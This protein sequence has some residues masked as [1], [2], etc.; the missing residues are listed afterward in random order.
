MFKTPFIQRFTQFLPPEVCER[1]ARSTGWLQRRGKIHP[2]EF[3]AGPT[4]AQAS[5]VHPSLSAQG[6]SYQQPVTPQAVDQRYNPQA[7]KFFAAAFEHTLHT[8]LEAQAGLPDRDLLQA[9]F[10][11]VRLF[12]STHFAVSES[13]AA[14]FPACGGG[15][16][17]AGIK[18]LLQHEY[19]R[20]QFQPL[21]LLPGKS[22]DQGL[23]SLAGA[24][25]GPGELGLFDKGF[26]HGAVL[27]EIHERGGYFLIPWPRSVTVWEVPPEGPAARV[28]LAQRL[29]HQEGN[30][31]ELTGMRLGQ[32][33]GALDEVRVLA[34][35]LR[36]ETANRRRAALREKCRTYGREP[37]AEA[38]ELAGW[39]IL[40]TNV[41]AEKLP[42]AVAGHLY[43]VRWQIEL[44][45]KQLKSVLRLDEVPSGKEDRMQCEV[46]AR[47]I[48]G[49]MLFTC[50]RYANAALGAGSR[51]QISFAKLARRFAQEGLALA[52]AIMAGGRELHQL[53]SR[54]WGQIL[55]SART[56]TQ[57]SRKTTWETLCD[58]WLD[59]VNAPATHA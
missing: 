2:T 48:A 43:R 7:V 50:H 29:R 32:G 21:V 26:F 38:L 6:Q 3:I 4:C 8:S 14:R 34:Y 11:A 36:E 54:L 58:C 25:V 12:D 51:R 15:G 13:L 35:R 19:L 39:E 27:R 31:L 46:W 1:L 18:V 49:V 44:V 17:A 37:K 57:K 47:L 30:G 56:G 42:R 45:F 28:E 23:A 33:E 52:R 22:S 40:L 9:Q 5:A 24:H 10:A 41:P 53:L 55:K 16:G 20:S 59:P